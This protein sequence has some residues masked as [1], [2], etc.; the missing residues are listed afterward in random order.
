MP[1]SIEPIRSAMPSA[2]GAVDRRHRQ[3]VVGGQR[4]GAVAAPP[5]G[6]RRGAS[7]AT[8]RGR[9]PTPRRRCRGRR[10]R[11]RRASSGMR[12]NPLASFWF[13]AGQW[14][15]VAPAAAT[16]AMSSSVRWTAWAS[17]VPGP[18]SPVSREHLDRR[19]AVAVADLGQLGV[20]LAGVD[21]DAGA[22]LGGELA[23]GAQLGLVEQVRAVR[24][25]PASAGRGGARAGR[26]PT[27]AGRRT[28]A[29]RR[30]GTR[31]TPA[32]RAGRKP[33]AA[34]T[35]RRRLGEEVHVE[36]GRD[37]G[38]QALGDRRARCRRRP[39][40]SD[41]TAPSAGSSRPRKR[42]EVEVVGEP[43]EH[44]HRQVGVGVDEAGHDDA[45]RGVDDVRAGGRSASVGP[46]D[47]M[48]VRRR[49]RS[50]P[51]VDARCRAASIV[52]TVRVGDGE[53]GR[54]VTTRRRRCRIAAQ[55][56]ADAL[57]RRRRRRR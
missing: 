13:E 22:V 18:S 26:R 41:S 11:R 48:I 43:A 12:A 21:V 51:L 36:G 46:T 55:Q 50:S 47:V 24:A 14:A 20:R 53:V 4:A 7:P 3:D 39:S 10:G 29:G 56:R 19:A 9:W 52:T 54:H 45:R 28:G 38:A 40:R 23:D 32:R 30:R 2:R 6:R 15:T 33:V 35:R 25:H 5:A 1:T 34:A 31:R 8:G 37:P 42:V 27:P 17:T 44:R 57:G 49:R 16:S